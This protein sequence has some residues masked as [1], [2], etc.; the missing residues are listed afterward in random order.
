M[1]SV[2]IMLLGIS[3]M[4]YAAVWVLDPVARL[5]G[6]EWIILLIGLVTSIVGFIYKD[7]KN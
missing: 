5:G 6:A 7:A 2:K 4:L 3:I 1:R